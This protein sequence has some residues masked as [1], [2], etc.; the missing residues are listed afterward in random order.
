[1]HFIIIIIGYNNLKKYN[2]LYYI[3]TYNIGTKS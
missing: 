1:M 2:I 3:I